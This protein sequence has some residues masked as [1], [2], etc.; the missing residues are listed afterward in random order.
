MQSHPPAIHHAVMTKMKENPGTAGLQA[1][2]PSWFQNML[3]TLPAPHIRSQGGGVDKGG[4]WHS[5]TRPDEISLHSVIQSS[6]LVSSM[7]KGI[8]DVEP[9]GQGCCAH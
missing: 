5:P 4:F 6:E 2:V 8:W 1:E 7:R 9:C 3:Q